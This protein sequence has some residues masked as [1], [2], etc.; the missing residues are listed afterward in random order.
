MNKM[1][2]MSINTMS[3]NTMSINTMSI[4]TMSINTMS[5]NT[6]NFETT[7]LNVEE[8]KNNLKNLIIQSVINKRN[9]VQEEQLIDLSGV[10]LS[11][12]DFSNVDLYKVNFTGSKLAH[13]NFSGADLTETRFIGAN[14]SNT[15]FDGANL[16]NTQFR[17]ANLSGAVFTNTI[18][19]IEEYILDDPIIEPIYGRFTGYN[20]NTA[21]NNTNVNYT[22]ENNDIL[23]KRI[24]MSECFRMKRKRKCMV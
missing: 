12:I 17:W 19:S 5:I 8:N 9:N 21:V 2:T 10:D 14:L 16:S 22:N 15:N 20:I 1:N 24:N 7:Y 6:M 23:K 4:N 18:F 3:I 11:D 13:C